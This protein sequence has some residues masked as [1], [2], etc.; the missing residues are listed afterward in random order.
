MDSVDPTMEE[1]KPSSVV[2]AFAKTERNP[3]TRHHSSTF[4]L[5]EA[6]REQTLQL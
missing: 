3:F 2:G 6:I 1:E 4:L 5:P